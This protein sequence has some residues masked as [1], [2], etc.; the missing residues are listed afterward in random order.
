ML[1]TAIKKAQ[2]ITRAS[3]QLITIL[4]LYHVLSL[5]PNCDKYINPNFEMGGSQ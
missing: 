4:T 1:Y 3:I 2:Q 5:E